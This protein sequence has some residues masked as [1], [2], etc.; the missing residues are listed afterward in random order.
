M[1]KSEW[2]CPITDRNAGHPIPRGMN[3]L[4]HVRIERIAAILS[5]IAGMLSY[6]APP[7]TAKSMKNTECC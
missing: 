2:S 5:W 3:F 4:D 7:G 6:F 1:P